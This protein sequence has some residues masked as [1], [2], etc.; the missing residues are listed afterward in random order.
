M[1]M[2]VG[3]EGVVRLVVVGVAVVHFSR[4]EVVESDSMR[5]W[6]VVVFEKAVVA[7]RR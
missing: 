6:R 7:D 2:K 1:S 3:V 4:V 5:R